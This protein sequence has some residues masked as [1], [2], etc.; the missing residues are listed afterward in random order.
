M[1]RGEIQ[2]EIIRLL[3]RANSHLGLSKGAVN[4]LSY[5]LR[6]TKEVDWEPGNAAIFYK[7]VSVIA[8]DLNLSERQVYN[9]EKSVCE[10][11][12]LTIRAT[13]NKRRFGKRESTAENRGK[14]I[15]AYGLDLSPLKE[16][17]Q[18]LRESVRRIEERRAEWA[19][20]KRLLAE[21]KRAARALGEMLVKLDTDSA[22]EFYAPP[23]E[24]SLR[25][26]VRT[27]TEELRHR[28][29]VAQR[30]RKEL[31]SAV[32]AAHSV[33]TSDRSAKNFRH[34]EYPTKDLADAYASVCTDADDANEAF[35]APAPAK[36]DI[37]VRF[38]SGAE[39]VSLRA[40]WNAASDRFRSL[41][42]DASDQNQLIT[43]AENSLRRLGITRFQWD[44]AC[45]ILGNY[46]AALC[47]LV[48]ERRQGLRQV[49]ASCA[50]FQA[51]VRRS[52]RG[53]LAVQRSIFGLIWKERPQCAA[54]T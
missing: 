35:S 32:L 39:Q 38:S 40:A 9:L 7:S 44:E 23:A 45:Q 6:H 5:A 15:F 47:V 11:F 19:K 53:K 28:V 33:K 16:K 14:I 24:L 20:F 2:F 29:D 18:S 8:S 42:G 30:Y 41:M 1:S 51:M 12:G 46:G 36:A 27:S 54:F 37:S 48:T 21:E 17:I 49:H 26:T 25:V 43:A 10:F 13:A 34:K 3:E 50:Y 52:L 22:A 4:F 31:E